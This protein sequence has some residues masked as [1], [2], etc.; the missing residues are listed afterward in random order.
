M[1]TEKIGNWKWNYFRPDGN[2]F[3]DWNATGDALIWWN[4][5]T[6]SF[7][8]EIDLV[9]RRLQP[10]GLPRF[11]E[12]LLVLS[13]CRKNWPEADGPSARFNAKMQ[14]LDP[15][16]WKDFPIYKWL[17]PMFD[18]LN[19]VHAVARREGFGADV[20]IA[21]LDAV[22]AGH[23][24]AIDVFSAS[25]I[26]KDLS[27]GEVTLWAQKSDH[28]VQWRDPKNP[29]LGLLQTV[30]NL[31]DVLESFNESLDLKLLEAT[32]IR[33]LVKPAS[34]ED[35]PFAQPVRQ[36]VADLIPE[37]DELAGVAR[38][39]RN[40]SAVVNLPRR[41][42]DPDEQPL[43]GYTDV[44]NRG[45]MD[46][47]LV[48]EMAQDP[49]VLAVRVALNEAL[50][51][52]R[53]SP[54]ND[55]PQRR[56]IFIDAGIRMWGLPRI[57][58]AA[59]A[60]AFAMQTRGKVV[61]E[62]FT[63]DEKMLLAAE[64]D[65]REGLTE[66]L[67]RLV[68]DP[69]PGA[70]VSRFF[71]K[72]VA[73][74]R[75]T[76]SVIITTPRVWKDAKFRRAIAE[77]RP[78]S[79]FVALVDR[80]GECRLLESNLA[81][82]RDVRTARL[83]LD[84][85]LETDSPESAKS[86]AGDDTLPM[87][88]RLDECPLRIGLTVAGHRA[89][90]HHELGVVGFTKDGLLLHWKNPIFGARL[91]T[92]LFP[93]RNPFWS[94][95]DAENSRVL[96]LFRVAPEEVLLFSADID[97]GVVQQTVLQLPFGG[98]CYAD[99]LSGA[100]LLYTKKEVYAFQV[101]DGR[102]VGRS[103]LPVSIDR[104]SR[105]FLIGEGRCFALRL[106]KPGV[107]GKD[108]QSR[109]VAIDHEGDAVEFVELSTANPMIAWTHSGFASPLVVQE[110]GEVWDTDDPAMKI[111]D[112]LAN[113]RPV[114]VSSDGERV[115]YLN[116][117]NNPKYMCLDVIRN[118]VSDVHGSCVVFDWERQG[119]S[120]RS[121]TPNIRKNISAIVLLTPGLLFLRTPKKDT[122][123]LK[124]V[125]RA[126]KKRMA[127]V[128][129]DSDE[130]D[131]G[132]IELENSDPR[133]SEMTAVSKFKRVELDVP[134]HVKFSEAELPGNNRAILDPRGLL[135]LQSANPDIPEVTVVLTDGETS[136]WCSDGAYFGKRYFICERESQADQAMK[137]IKAF[138]ADVLKNNR[139]NAPKGVELG[140][141][142]RK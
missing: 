56:L 126:S 22:F 12:I 24:D 114:R 133:L 14:Q 72:E 88:L 95:I 102:C 115:F 60:L 68:P 142:L 139:S 120:I 75:E 48:S 36:L 34:V 18:G 105:G 4:G 74:E 53:E 135:H 16:G 66:L 50:Y 43:G 42:S 67:E 79:F 80:D 6:L 64:I 63:A 47:L 37:D 8:Q 123:A 23:G 82:E 99:Y 128:L 130:R 20:T 51:L 94:T 46:R 89:M 93:K 86:L 59:T 113:H 44:T 98:G 28:R 92:T 127:W 83:D 29:P 136:G 57:Y 40:L 70:G 58:A 124:A 1:T 71:E 19:R 85:L 32:G 100:V 2:T 118:Q 131:S 125:E 33:S 108:A 30:Q 134:G 78:D 26:A 104:Q 76:E 116:Q 3:W 45:Q 111:S 132:S 110:S 96:Y 25:E 7:Y 121:H 61:T 11:E 137:S 122:L 41:L 77:H 91:V 13:A 138:V 87:F 21:I 5:E 65:T 97:S 103:Q 55:P 112:R 101:N 106:K 141:G 9:I 84:S 69:H 35:V 31:S 109:S 52:R 38:I 107:S 27:I 81:G 117:K 15:A 90:H 17:G 39:A 62:A 10:H 129:Q 73:D 54:P 49:D 119:I 140:E